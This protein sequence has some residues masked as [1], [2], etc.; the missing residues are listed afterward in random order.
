M[1]QL[2]KDTTVANPNGYQPN[3]EAAVINA[4]A[5]ECYETSKEHGFQ[6]DY[7]SADWLEALAEYLEKEDRFTTDSTSFP[8]VETGIPISTV[9]GLRRCA[10]IM[11]NNVIGTKLMLIVCELAEGMETLRATSVFGHLEGEGN[12]GEELADASVRLGD[13]ASMLRVALGD[14][15]IRKM[16][17]NK[18][19]PHKHGKNL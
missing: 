15:Q 4:V 12:L 16:L 3:V 5:L 9:G 10:E 1:S 2:D 17:V 6:D 7:L 11:R 18:S 13:T 14:E 19:R 8:S